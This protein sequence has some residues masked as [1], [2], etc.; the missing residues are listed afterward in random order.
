MLYIELVEQRFVEEQARRH[1]EARGAYVAV[2]HHQIVADRE[3]V[4]D[5]L[6]PPGLFKIDVR[7]LVER[8]HE[9]FL[10][11]L[12]AVDHADKRE[13]VF[14]RSG[15][16]ARADGGDGVFLIVDL[17]LYPEPLAD[18]GVAAEHGVVKRIAGLVILR[19]Y[20][21]GAHVIG[22]DDHAERFVVE[23]DVGKPVVQLFAVIKRVVR[24]AGRAGAVL[25]A[26]HYEH[27][28]NGKRRERKQ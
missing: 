15:F 10:R 1:A 19:V 7:Q 6:I 8:E 24:I 17:D 3:A 16:D 23:F 2:Y 4:P 11:E 12:R 22:G 28:R 5:V 18:V 21:A 20:V 13:I 14:I 25:T 26:R 27:R 9:V